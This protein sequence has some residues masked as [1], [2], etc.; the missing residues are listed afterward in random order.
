MAGVNTNF[1]SGRPDG[2]NGAKPDA[3]GEEPVSMEMALAMDRNTV[4]KKQQH[5]PREMKHIESSEAW[6]SDIKEV[7]MVRLQQQIESLEL[8]EQEQDPESARQHRGRGGQ[9]EKL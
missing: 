3:G 9:I 1:A 8:Q 7:A 6:D 5:L 4:R 2:C